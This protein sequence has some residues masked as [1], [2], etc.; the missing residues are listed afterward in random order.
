MYCALINSSKFSVSILTW[1]PRKSISMDSLDLITYENKVLSNSEQEEAR[2]L[3]KDIQD[4][5]TA[6][7]KICITGDSVSTENPVLTD[8][9]W[10]CVI[11][12]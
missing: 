9:P 5:L 8:K 12:L 1:L 10:K 6:L 3:L 4:S 2:K 7:S 11:Y